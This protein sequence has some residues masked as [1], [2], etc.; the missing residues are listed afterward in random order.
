M[1]RKEK[2]NLLFFLRSVSGSHLLANISWNGS[3]QELGGRESGELLFN[4]DTIPVLQ[5]E[6]GYGDGW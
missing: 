3:C 1:N 6:K 4:E 5:V 2:K